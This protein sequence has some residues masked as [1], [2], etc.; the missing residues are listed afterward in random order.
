MFNELFSKSL[1]GGAGKRASDH[2]WENT[3][4]KACFSPFRFRKA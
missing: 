2:Y 4:S 1:G 3:V